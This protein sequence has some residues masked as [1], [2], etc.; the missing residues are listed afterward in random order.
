M[1]KKRYSKYEKVID[2]FCEAVNRTFN[3]KLYVAYVDRRHR[4]PGYYFACKLNDGSIRQATFKD[5]FGVPSP[6]EDFKN[7]FHLLYNIYGNGLGIYDVN[8][9]W[10]FLNTKQFGKD[11]YEVLMNIDLL[12]N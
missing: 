9:N 4:F 2:K 3:A 6:F 7:L 12:L 8:G 5:R 1:K 10:H 11:V